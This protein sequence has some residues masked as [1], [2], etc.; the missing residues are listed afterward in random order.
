[1]NKEEIINY[2]NDVIED[3]QSLEGSEDDIKHELIDIANAVLETIACH[4]SLNEEE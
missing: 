3:I 1:M 2:L 4:L